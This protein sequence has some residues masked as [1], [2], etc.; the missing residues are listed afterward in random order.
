MASVINGRPQLSL[1]RGP[2]LMLLHIIR[3]FVLELAR[4]S[5]RRL[6]QLFG[7]HC[8][9]CKKRSHTL[10]SRVQYDAHIRECVHVMILAQ[11][12]GSS[13]LAKL[14]KK[15]AT[16]ALKFL[17]VR[18]ERREKERSGWGVVGHMAADSAEPGS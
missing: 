1:K 7:R 10:A 18:V 15:D 14:A 3:Y 11:Q 8:N 17:P 12:G 4:K 5:A 13:F 16:N 6:L 2:T 9:L